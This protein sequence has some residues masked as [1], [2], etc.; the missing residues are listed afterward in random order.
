MQYSGQEDRPQVYLPFN[1]LPLIH[2]ERLSNDLRNITF[3]IRTSQ[4][5]SQI[6]SQLAGAVAEADRSQAV[7][8]IRTMRDTAFAKEVRRFLAELIGTFGAIAVMMAVVGVYG[9]M[10]QTVNQRTNEI[11]IR[12]ALGA[13]TS[14]VRRLVIRHGC[15]IIA[16]GLLVGTLGALAVTRV[17]RSYL[18]GLSPTDPLTFLLG[19]G[20]LGIIALLACYVP[21]RR[22]SRIDPMLALRHE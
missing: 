16:T 14:D 12:M 6:A 4:P 11:G 20:V 13:N 3:V 5:V 21:A 7:S 18:L 8:R 15:V 9:V 2:D 10:A 1:Q 17:L 19:L 22:A